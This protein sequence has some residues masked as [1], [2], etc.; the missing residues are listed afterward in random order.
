MAGDRAKRI[1]ALLARRP[2]VVYAARHRC[3]CGAG[4]AYTTDADPFSGAWD[5]AAILTGTAIP[6][7]EPG[8]VEHTARLP[9]VF[10]EIKSERQPSAEGATTRPSP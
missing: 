2:D 3:P 8:A 9:F 4:L 1:R 10:Y 5:C 6:S 7:G